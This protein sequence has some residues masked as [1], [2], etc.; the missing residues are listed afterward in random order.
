MI[1]KN[2]LLQLAVI[3]ILSLNPLFSQT[4]QPHIENIQ[5]HFDESIQAII[6]TYDLL[7]YSDRATYQIELLF[8][9]AN[10]VPVYPETTEGDL[11]EGIKGGMNKQIVWEI[12][13]D[14]EGLTETVQPQLNI[15][16]IQEIHIDPTID[17]IMD[18]INEI[19]AQKYR[20]KI[21]RDGLMIFGVG[22]AVGSIIFK[23]KAD[24]YIDQQ[25]LVTMDSKDL[26][27]AVP[28][29]ASPYYSDLF[30]GRHVSRYPAV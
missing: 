25:N 1:G 6:I 20:F 23:L 7:N 11:G 15:I 5:F 30:W 3:L 22:A 27:H 18:Q 21:Q 28:H 12:Y 10:N 9:G 2:H 16:A 4:T 8:V 19:S 17:D 29:Q 26:C 14:I 13:N 24:D